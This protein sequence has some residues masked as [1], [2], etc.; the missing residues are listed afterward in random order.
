M[1]HFFTIQ[2]KTENSATILIYD[3]IGESYWSESVSAK[4]FVSELM[5]L[6]KEGFNIDIRLNCPGGSVFDGLAMYNAIHNAKGEI[7]MHNDGHAASMGAVLLFASSKHK[8]RIAKNALTMFHAAITGA[9]GNKEKMKEAI[10]L[11]EKVESC[12][13]ASIQENSGMDEETIKEKYF[14]DGKDHWLNLDDLIADGFVLVEEEATDNDIE[15]IRNKTVNDMLSNCKNFSNI[16]MKKPSNNTESPANKAITWLK[17]LVKNQKEEMKYQKI[18]DL[19]QVENLT[20]HEG[21]VAISAEH[22]QKIEDKLNEEPQPTNTVDTGA[23]EKLDKEVSN[24]AIT[25]GQL[26]AEKEAHNATKQEFENYKNSQGGGKATTMTPVNN[27]Q[28]GGDEELSE[29]DVLNQCADFLG[30]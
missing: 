6:D 9:Y 5:A 20:E 22:F 11:L 18:K 17:N 25:K 10:Q 4:K 13:I 2:N 21:M 26:D 12:L 1:E 7:Y 15:N 8:P 30:E 16:P 27:G 23:K 28:E 24:H 14:N 19:L 29:E 3:A